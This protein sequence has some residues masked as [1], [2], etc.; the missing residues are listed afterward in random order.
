MFQ[1]DAMATTT[2][3]PASVGPVVSRRPSAE[4][5]K[6]PRRRSTTKDGLAAEFSTC[7]NPSRP[8]PTIRRLTRQSRLLAAK[9]FVSKCNA[10]RRTCSCA[11]ALLH[12]VA[13]S[14][15]SVLPAAASLWA[16]Q[17][18]ARHKTNACVVALLPAR[19]AQF[20]AQ[21]HLKRGLWAA[22]RWR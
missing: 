11:S 13:A 6:R 19:V 3:A 1:R 15:S 4:E 17:S 9:L 22:S 20:R 16:Y 14:E 2:A 8:T 18:P 12:D 10:R 7:T 21:S 5:Q